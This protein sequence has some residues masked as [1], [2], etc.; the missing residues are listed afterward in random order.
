[1]VRLQWV[2]PFMCSHFIFHQ[3]ADLISP[4]LTYM[5]AL[6]NRSLN[7]M[8]AQKRGQILKTASIFLAS[9]LVIEIESAVY[10]VF[11]CEF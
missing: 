1:M 9:I 2:V 11:L 7:K 4:E 6:K 8:T 3:S 5:R 10:T